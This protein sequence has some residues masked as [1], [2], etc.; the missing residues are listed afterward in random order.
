MESNERKTKCVVWDLDNTIWDG[1]IIEDSNVTLRSGIRDIIVELDR[2]GI[3]QSVASKNDFDLAFAK[4]REFQL[5]EYFLYWPFHL[6]Y[7]HWRIQNH[8]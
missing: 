6:L 3:L 2:R 7:R 5:H 1:V 4:L 8:H